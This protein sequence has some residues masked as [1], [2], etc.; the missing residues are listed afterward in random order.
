MLIEERRVAG[1]GNDVQLSE[2]HPDL[3]KRSGYESGQRRRFR[4]GQEERSS[5]CWSWWNSG[6]LDPTN[7]G[8]L[9]LQAVELELHCLTS[10]I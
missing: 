8:L 3:A 5:C 2:G 9:A 1:L 10:L 4:S 6:A 7:A